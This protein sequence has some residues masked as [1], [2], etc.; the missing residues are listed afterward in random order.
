MLFFFFSSEKRVG[1][2]KIFLVVRFVFL[3]EKR[4]ELVFSE[5][6]VSWVNYSRLCNFFETIFRESSSHLVI[7][8]SG[9][10]DLTLPEKLITT[11]KPPPRNRVVKK[12]AKSSY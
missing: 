7:N 2:G 12:V 9:R 8:F 1:V 5:R 3:C 4:G 6:V 11:W 10:V